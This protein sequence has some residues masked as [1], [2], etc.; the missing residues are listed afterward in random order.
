M[1]D[2]SP[3]VPDSPSI[4]VEEQV[5]AVIN[6]GLARATQI[7]MLSTG[8]PAIMEARALPS[9]AMRRTRKIYSASL[10]AELDSR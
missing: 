1:L 7:S 5:A 6:P 2:Q 9:A 10:R 3:V 8:A 4:T